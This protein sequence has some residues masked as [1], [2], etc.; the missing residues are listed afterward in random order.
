VNIL[1]QY[2]KAVAERRHTMYAVT[3][4]RELRVGEEFEFGGAS[5]QRVGDTVSLRSR[6]AYGPVYGYA[7]IIKIDAGGFK[8]ARR[9]K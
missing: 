4:L 6:H 1:Q 5:W 9:T 8:T 3:T 7:Q 2:K